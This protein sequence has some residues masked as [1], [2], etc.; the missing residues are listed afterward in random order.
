M[1]TGSA[2][3]AQNKFDHM[4]QAIAE[5]TDEYNRLASLQK[6]IAENCAVFFDAEAEK[7][8]QATQKKQAQ[9]LA[10][11]EEMRLRMTVYVH[12]VQI[13]ENALQRR[14]HIIDAVDSETGVMQHNNELLN[15]FASGQV[16]LQ[17]DLKRLH[18]RVGID[19]GAAVD[20]H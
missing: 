1:E 4:A 3:H 15:V 6:A 20:L 17:K 12:D 2:A 7:V 9:L 5:L 13:V 18:T 10:L 11:K 8:N 16:M 14:Q 19:P